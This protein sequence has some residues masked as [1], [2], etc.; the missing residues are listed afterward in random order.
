MGVDSGP[1]PMLH[2]CLE[3]ICPLVLCNPADKPSNENITSWDWTRELWWKLSPKSNRKSRLMIFLRGST[4][5]S[6]RLK[7]V[8]VDSA[9]ADGESEYSGNVNNS[10]SWILTDQPMA[11]NPKLLIRSK[12]YPRRNTTWKTTKESDSVQWEPDD[13]Y[14]GSWMLSTWKT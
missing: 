7:A 12:T 4:G 3:E 10:I 14:T 1:A 5:L 2:P 8:S 9:A 6:C 13:N 11:S